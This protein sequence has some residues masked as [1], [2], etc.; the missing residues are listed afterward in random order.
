MIHVCISFSREIYKS[1]DANPSLEVRGVFLDIYKAFDRVWHDGLFYKLK[2][3]G[4]CGILQLNTVIFGKQTS[5]G[6]PQWLIIEM[7]FS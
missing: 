7:V 2:L 1:F 3:L 6:R 5:K 4:I